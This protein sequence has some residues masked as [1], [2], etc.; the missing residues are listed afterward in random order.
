MGKIRVAEKH[1]ESL[2][3]RLEIARKEIDAYLVKMAKKRGIHLDP[4][5]P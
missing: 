4:L 3:E 1:R 5:D 2:V